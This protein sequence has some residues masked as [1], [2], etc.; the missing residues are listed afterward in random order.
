VLPTEYDQVNARAYNDVLMGV[1]PS[2]PSDPEYMA[3]YQ[4]WATI[5]DTLPCPA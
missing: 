4:F 1:E 3:C 5:A 2:C